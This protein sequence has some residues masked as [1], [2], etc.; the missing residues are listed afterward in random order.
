MRDYR[1]NNRIIVLNGLVAFHDVE[2]IDMSQ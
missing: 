1:F 2:S